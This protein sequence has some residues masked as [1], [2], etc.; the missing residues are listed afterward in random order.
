MNANASP[1]PRKNPVHFKAAQK[2]GAVVTFSCRYAA[3]SVMM[4]LGNSF[5]RV[6]LENLHNF[7]KNLGQN[8]LLRKKLEYF[9]IGQP[10]DL[11]SKFFDFLDFSTA[12][13]MK[14]F[15][16]DFR[17]FRSLIFWLTDFKM[18]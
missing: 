15:D 8:G 12:F 6:R 10:K 11:R 4:D 2:W 17:N 1:N 3:L 5:H 13:S 18:L 16:D 14:I 7:E 9:G